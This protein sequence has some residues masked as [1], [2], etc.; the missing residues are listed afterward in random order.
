MVSQIRM[1]PILPLFWTVSC[2]TFNCTKGHCEGWPG[3]KKNHEDE[4]KNETYSVRK[5]YQQKKR[6]EEK[7]LISCEFFHQLFWWSSWI[8]SGCVV[9]LAYFDIGGLQVDVLLCSIAVMTIRSVKMLLIC[10]TDFFGK[11]AKIG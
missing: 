3:C 2:A 1:Q 11:L 9:G 8:L 5:Q 6:A 10:N 4:S 7:K